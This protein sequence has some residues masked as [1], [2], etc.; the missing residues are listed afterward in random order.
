MS[1]PI[2]PELDAE[3]ARR[4]VELI[5]ALSQPRARRRP[6]TPAPDRVAGSFSSAA[7]YSRL[8]M[9]WAMYSLDARRK[10]GLVTQNF[11]GTSPGR[12]PVGLKM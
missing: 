5:A 1:E 9:R 3:A 7:R 10:N 8:S 4:L 6:P 12:A 11:C 2:E